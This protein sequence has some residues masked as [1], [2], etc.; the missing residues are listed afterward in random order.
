M[1]FFRNARVIWFVTLVLAIA[2]GTYAFGW[3]AV[4]VI[5][6]AWAWIRRTDAAVPLLAALA[7]LAGWGLLLILPAVTGGRVREI[8]DVVGAAMQVGGG[9]LLALTLAFPAL[10]AGSVA[11]VV[12]GIGGWRTSP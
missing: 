12:R 5:A 9:P 6:G 7:G 1:S 3:V 11:G 2:L 8:A 10:L 4:G